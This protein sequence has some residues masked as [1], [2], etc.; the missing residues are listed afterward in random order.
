MAQNQDLTRVGCDGHQAVALDCVHCQHRC[1]ACSKGQ[2]IFLQPVA[3]FHSEKLG[4]A[5]RRQAQAHLLLFLHGQVDGFR[6][7]PT[8]HFPLGEQAGVG[9]Q[10]QGKDNPQQVEENQHHGCDDADAT[11]GDSP[12]RN[13]VCA[14][15]PQVKP[16]RP[17]GP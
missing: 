5:R 10:K 17:H 4:L 16:F 13:V 12:A 6:V 3:G 9:G 7:L 11:H 1:R 15:P 8:G 14:R 2:T